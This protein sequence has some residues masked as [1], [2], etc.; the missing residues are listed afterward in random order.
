MPAIGNKQSAERKR[1]QAERELLRG[2]GLCDS[3]A[4]QKFTRSPVVRLGPIVN[5]NKN[6]I[7][8]L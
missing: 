4:S 6:Q 1:L 5:S 2:I 7:S 8:I 3:L